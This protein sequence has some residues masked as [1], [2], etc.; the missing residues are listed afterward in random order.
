MAA[1]LQRQRRHVLITRSG[2]EGRALAQRVEALGHWALH[3]PLVELR[4]VPDP[5]LVRDAFRA[6]PAVDGV[7]ITSREGVRQSQALGLLGLLS[8]KNLPVP[9]V[10]P[11]SGTASLARQFGVSEIV[12][13]A[14]GSG[15]SERVL[16]L[17]LF[18]SI[19]DQCWVIL[20]AADGRRLL[21]KVLRERGSQVERL[22]VYERHFVP[23]FQAALDELGRQSDWFTLLASGAVLARLQAELS[24]S[25]WQRICRGPMV[26]PSERLLDQA[27]AMGVQQLVLSQ[28][29]SDDAMLDALG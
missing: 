21:D 28:G 4:A 29:A 10:V 11:G 24:A 22:V 9:L 5:E 27:D 15:A 3:L 20:A 23:P 25:L 8:E 17:D 2:E 16:E 12:Y 14:A 18:R 19:Q 26:V 13:P 1:G 7:I 6:L